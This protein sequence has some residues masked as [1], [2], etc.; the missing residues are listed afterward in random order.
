MRFPTSK[1]WNTLKLMAA[2]AVA[3]AVGFMYQ[4]TPDSSSNVISVVVTIVSILAGFLVAAMVFVTKPV[5]KYARDGRELQL[6]KK[7]VKRMLLRFRLIFF[8][9]IITL[10]LS[11]L[12]YVSPSQ[13]RWILEK[14]FVS[15]SFFDLLISFTLPKTLIAIHMQ[16]YQ[17]EIDKFKPDVVKEAERNQ[18]LRR[19]K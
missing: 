8:L 12:T 13:Y 1:S 7:S 5:I 10:C 2:L 18:A 9:F 15:I 6:M 14:V 4:P 16:M 3:S 11:I 17:L 19:V